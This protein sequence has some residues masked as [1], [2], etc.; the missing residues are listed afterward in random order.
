M[1]GTVEEK[2]INCLESGKSF[3]LDAGAGSG[4]TWTLVQ[5]LNYLLDRKSDSLRKNKQKIACITYTNIAKDEIIERTEYSDLIQ[6]STIHDFLWDCI[7]N[8]Q[9]ELKLELIRLVEKKLSKVQEEINKTKSKITK[10][11]QELDERKTKYEVALD[12]LRSTELPIRYVSYAIYKKG[13]FKHDDLLEISENMFSRYSILKKIVT[14]SYPFL[15]V[16]EYQ[17]TQEETIKILLEYLPRNSQFILGF[18]GD[19][20]QQ[21][22]ETG[23]GEIDYKKYNLEL[24]QKTE[25][26]RSSK[27]VIELLNK[28][29]DD[30]QQFQPPKNKQEGS[31]TFYYT[32]NINF[33]LNDFINKYLL[34][35]W[36]VGSKDKIKILFLTHRFIAKENGYE[37]LYQLHSQNS[38]VLIKNKD[39]RGF[40]PYTD[41]L[42]DIEEIADCFLYGKIQN[43]LKLIDCEFNSFETKK[44]LNTLLKQFIKNR[45]EM[46]IKEIIDFV[47]TNDLLVASDRMNGYDFEDTEKKEF[48]EELL[49]LNYLQFMKFY[50]VNQDK[51]PF[52][53]K[54]NTKGDEF[55][56]VLAIIDD[57]SWKQKYNF[58]EYFSY[59]LENLKRFN[60]TKNLFYV[61]CSRAKKNLAILCVSELSEKSRIQVKELFENYQEIP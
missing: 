3:I 35:Q 23:I 36:N 33:N 28:L 24:I 30:L 34:S 21:I 49:S 46:T 5:T 52:S 14:D 40:S 61:V 8:F 13:K 7:K 42:F 44:K 55:D 27:K 32:P 59:K 19:K 60:L 11:Y 56:N 58:E 26:Y 17:D 45:E 54:H 43:L 15:F 2:I 51:T 16:D 22:Y 10:K 18:F 25:N 41:F 12:T 31:V 38:E 48:Y 29:R 6:V 39:N 4:K 53:T 1:A 50:Q 47:I 37:E 20:V 9:L 57:T